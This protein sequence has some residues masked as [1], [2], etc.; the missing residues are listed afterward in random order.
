MT[1]RCPSRR[2]LHHCAIHSRERLRPL[3]AASLEAVV[4]T[5]RRIEEVA[6]SSFGRGKR[7]RSAIYQR[8][9]FLVDLVL[10]TFTQCHSTSLSSPANFSFFFFLT[11]QLFGPDFQLHALQIDL[12]TLHTI[13]HPAIHDFTFWAFFLEAQAPTEGMSDPVCIA[14]M[15]GTATTQM[16][17]YPVQS[18]CYRRN[19]GP[20]F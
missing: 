10:P 9:W 6:E 12:N 2:A 18:H 4:R 13:T 3:G 5:W 7:L 20:A 8:V 19:S 1:V 15:Y 11:F 16:D 17:M 14:V